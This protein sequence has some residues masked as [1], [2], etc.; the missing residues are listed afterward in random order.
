[1]TIGTGIAIASVWVFAGITS[2]GRNISGTGILVSIIVASV[3][4]FALK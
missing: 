4:T 3:V 2:A 1:M